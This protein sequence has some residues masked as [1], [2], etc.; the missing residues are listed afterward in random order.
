MKTPFVD[1]KIQY[2]AIKEEIDSAIRSVIEETAFVRGKYVKNFEKEYAAAYGVGNCVSVANGTDAIYIALK[3]L[4]IGPGDEVITVANSWISTSEVITQAGAKPV[5]ADID[6]DYYTIDPAQVRAKLSE[7]TRAVIPVHLFGQSAEM[8]AIEDL[9]RERGLHLIEDCAQAH[10]AEYRRR[11]GGAARKVGTI[12]RAGTFSFYP[13][14]NLGAYGDAGAIVTADEALANRMTMYA[15]HGSLVKHQHEI[16]GIN[17]RLDGLQAAILSAKL[18][19]IQD[20]NRRRHANA[21]VYN[22][23]LA[24]VG[25]VTIPK[26][27]PNGT[28]VFH[29]YVIRTAH[30]DALQKHLAE[31][32]IESGIHYPVAL[33]FLKAYAYLKHRPE[34]F[35]VAHRFQGEILSLPMFPELTR[36]QIEY[37]SAEI[38]GFFART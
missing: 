2:R 6:P 19:H 30:R 8:D 36:E 32:G 10:F 21:L 12:G 37:V 31:K 13:G 1:L 9:C 16:E 23:M 33:P 28:H 22:E 26:I 4:G 29:L 17:S 25:D 34:D 15:N 35:P 14:K 7:R 18:R 3:S 20:W 5:F 11:D 27:R 38:R 24:G